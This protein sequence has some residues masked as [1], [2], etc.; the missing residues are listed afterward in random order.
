MP[1]GPTPQPPGPLPKPTYPLIPPHLTIRLITDPL[2][3]L[4]QPAPHPIPTT[5]TNEPP[6]KYIRGIPSPQPPPGGA[7]RP[8]RAFRYD[9]FYRPWDRFTQRKERAKKEVGVQDPVPS[10]ER[11]I[12]GRPTKTVVEDENG[13]LS[14]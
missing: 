9:G 11:D 6:R 14:R 13:V 2:P 4:P 10:L 12:E 7:R 8:P 5:P 1:P 3:A